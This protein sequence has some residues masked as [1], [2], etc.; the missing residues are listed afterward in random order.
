VDAGSVVWARAVVPGEVR[1]AGRVA[2]QRVA[3]LPRQRRAAILAHR[4]ADREGRVRGLTV[5][6]DDF[7]LL[8]DGSVRLRGSRTAPTLVLDRLPR[9]QELTLVEASAVV[10]PPAY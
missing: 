7:A 1:E 8:R 9:L 3:E 10:A 4:A 5:A 2:A 6:R